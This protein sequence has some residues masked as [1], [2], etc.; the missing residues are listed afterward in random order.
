MEIILVK[1]QAGILVADLKM[2]LIALIITAKQDL[3]ARPNLACI[4]DPPP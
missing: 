2:D 1:W 4:S 3:Y